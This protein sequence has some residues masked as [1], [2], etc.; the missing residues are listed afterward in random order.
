MK[1]EKS[2]APK[3]MQR[4][5]EQERFFKALHGEDEPEETAVEPQ[6]EETETK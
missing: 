3:D 2:K 4:T 6:T 1:D 5:P